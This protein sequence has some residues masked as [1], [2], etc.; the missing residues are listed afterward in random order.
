MTERQQTRTYAAYLRTNHFAT[1][2][3]TALETAK[4]RCQTCGSPFDLRVHHN[5]YENL[6]CEA[7]EDMFV[8][9]GSC[10]ADFHSVRRLH[11]KQLADVDYRALLDFTQANHES[12]PEIV[13]DEPPVRRC[14]SCGGRLKPDG[15]VY[16]G[17]ACEG[18]LQARNERGF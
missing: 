7:P 2:R 11:G 3:F 13:E 16:C 15:R 1:V 12:E 10:H 14:P 18:R 17:K 5:T 6:T 8:M 9:C 4:Y